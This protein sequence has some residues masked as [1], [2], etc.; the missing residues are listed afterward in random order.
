M[1]RGNKDIY[2]HIELVA[3]N[4]QGVGDVFLNN[5]IVQVIKVTQGINEFDPTPSAFSDGF[6][7][8]VVL[9][10]IQEFLFMKFLGELGKL[11]GQVKG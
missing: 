8:P 5:D 4:E 10:P 2:P 11:F 3:L 1:E 6:H 7:Y 9:V